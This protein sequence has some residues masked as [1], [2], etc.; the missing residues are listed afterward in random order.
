MKIKD[1]L[2]TR[3]NL[4]N[5]QIV[6]KWASDYEILA[7]DT[8]DAGY[9]NSQLDLIFDFE[10]LK[11]QPNIVALDLIP[12]SGVKIS[13]PFSKDVYGSLELTFGMVN[14][15]NTDGIA[16]LPSF[17]EL[18]NTNY[19]LFHMPAII[20]SLDGI[21]HLSK[22]RYFKV[23]G[24]ATDFD[25]KRFL[26]FFK[27]KNLKYL[28]ASDAGKENEIG[29]ALAIVQKHLKEKDIA[30]CMDELIEAGLKEYA[31]L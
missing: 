11:I 30:E 17:N 24:G 28:E 16:V 25:D 6:G 23:A 8:D 26:R 31:K 29:K 7:Q 13:W 1:L 21:E 2:E 14:G 20:K 4:V 10:T 9:D 12:K 27:A 3:V 22:L 15:R 19:I 18:P 5:S